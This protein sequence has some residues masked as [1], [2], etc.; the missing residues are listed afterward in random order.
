MSQMT[1]IAHPYAQALFRLAK[2]REEQKF[3]MKT[4]ASLAEVSK[5]NEFHDMLNNPKVDSQQIID[6][7]RVLLD[8][9]DK[10]VVNLLS[11]LADNNRLLALP[12]IYT[13]FRELVLEDQKRADAIIESAYEMSSSE[14]EEFEQIL[15]KKFGKTI[16]ASVKV[17]P[18]LIAGIKVTIDDKVIDGSVK[19]RLENLA[20]QLT[21]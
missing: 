16:T 3:W 6:V 10:D 15:S 1:I 20:T 8:R 12:E 11:M 19:G 4:L 21:K 9:D 13:V 14:I 5:S 2:E 18:D 17:N 7:I